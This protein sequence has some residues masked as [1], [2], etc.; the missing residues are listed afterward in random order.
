MAPRTKITEE[1]LINFLNDKRC[2]F[3][4]IDLNDKNKS[5]SKITFECGSGHVSTRRYDTVKKNKN[6]CAICLKQ[7]N[8]LNRDNGVEDLVKKCGYNL[9]E[10]F[11]DTDNDRKY[12]MIKVECK[13]KHEKTLHC[14]TDLTIGECKKCLLELAKLSDKLYC[15]GCLDDLPFDN[16]NNCESNVYRLGK[17]H[18]CRKCRFFQHSKIDFMYEHLTFENI[19][20][21]KC[22]KCVCWKILD[23]FSTDNNLQDKLKTF[24]KTCKQV[25]DIK[26]NNNNLETFKEATKYEKKGIKVDDIKRQK[27]IEENNTNEKIKII[28]KQK[29]LN[30]QSLW[31]DNVVRQI[32]EKEKYHRC[33]QCDYKTENSSLFT[34]H[35]ANIHDIN[36]KWKNCEYCEDKFKEKSTLKNHLA[37]IHNINVTWTNCTQE[38]C[39]FR[40]KQKGTLSSHLAN[41]HNIN[42]TYHE[43]EFCEFKTKEKSHV[44]RHLANIHNIGV[45]WSKCDQD[46]C[47]FK[48]KNNTDLNK[49]KSNIH[50]IG[51]H[52]CD[53]C[54]RNRNSSIKHKDSQGNHKIC[55]KC[56]RKVSGKNSRI[57][58]SWSDYLDEKFGTEY[59]LVSDR[60]IY[61]E[62]CQKYRPDKLYASPNLIIHKEC[63][64]NQHLYNNGSYTCDEKRISDI[65]D[66]FVNKTS[67]IVTRWNPHTYKVPEGKEKLNRE[68]RLKLD[69]Y[70]TEKIREISKKLP[71]IFIIYMCYNKDNPRLSKNI[72]H[73][74]I[75]DINDFNNFVESL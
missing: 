2:T 32:E 3:K 11:Y 5:K 24:C 73:V 60:M 19:E 12:K 10:I 43:C 49:H 59:L 56:F 6:I 48:C 20:Y 66:E 1:Y 28:N 27:E 33:E 26:D 75:Y 64:E 23:C 13:G 61:G 16:F 22:S 9:I 30:K 53:F 37:N 71:K 17:D 58:E 15:P 7:E 29:E 21:K 40:C 65:Y 57:E 8:E 4:K 46:M 41:I 18:Y 14:K 34:R 31:L 68:E 70:V 69:L 74:L 35:L 51:E 47:D 63:D 62:S 44:K 38:N 72:P 54:A 52:K 45:K 67:Y 39:N 55:K 50:D 25:M 36:V 42:V